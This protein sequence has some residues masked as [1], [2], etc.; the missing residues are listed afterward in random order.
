MIGLHEPL[1]VLV[2]VADVLE[3]LGVPYLVGGS[4]ATSLLGVPRLTQDAD[5][6]ADL[7]LQHVRPF[8]AATTDAFYIDEDAVREAV[9]RRG[10]FN[11]VHL[12]TLFKV[13]VFVQK[14]DPLSVAEMT[15]RTMFRITKDPPREI[16]LASAE[17]VILQKLDWFRRGGGVSD[18]QWN[19]VLGVVKVR[20]ATL[21]R[22]YLSEWARRTDLEDLLAR[23]LEG[24]PPPR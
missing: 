11:L 15:R 17:D 12:A 7:E 4:I 10:S 20:G 1:E 21:D 16:P 3:A 6:V 19:D 2:V 8:V 13:D 5:L 14:R 22:T 23:A 24:K 9:R 18:R